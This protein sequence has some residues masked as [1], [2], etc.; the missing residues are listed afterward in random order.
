MTQ[1]GGN[2]MDITFATGTR[3]TRSGTRW[4]NRA[5]GAAGL[6]GGGILSGIL[7]TALYVAHRI[8]RPTPTTPFDSFTFT[9]FEFGIPYDAVALPGGDGVK[10]PGWWMYRADSSRVVIICIGYRGRRADMLGI[11]AALWRDGN[12][13]LI[14]DYRGHGELAGTPVTLG[15]REVQDLLSAVAWAKSQVPDASIGVLGYSMGGSVAIMG[16]A[17]SQ[18]IRAVVADSP[19]ASQREV[20]GL[21]VRRV[22]RVPHGPLL[23]VVDLLLGHI[24]GYHFKDVEPLREVPL[25]APRPLL[26]IH[27]DADSVTD[28]RDSQALYDAAGEPKDLWL[29]PDVEHC[30]VYFADRSYYCERVTGFFRRALAEQALPAAHAAR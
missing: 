7:A 30:G 6:A 14:F 20:V 27:G 22:L 18:D 5:I 16:A 15:Y 9:P 25:I 23:N 26:L 11:G 29:V 3:Y 4:I 13:V 8:T 17:R 10:L 2:N 21:T 28:P 12:N 1:P 19:F 24:G